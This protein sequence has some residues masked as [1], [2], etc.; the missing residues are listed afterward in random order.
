[1]LE[2]IGCVT[3]EHNLWLVALAAV[4]CFGGSALTLRLFGRMRCAPRDRRLLQLAMTCIIGGSTI[5]TTHF[6]AMLA[7]EPGIDHAY[8]PVLTALSLFAAIAGVTAAFA[9]ASAT[10]RSVLVEIGGALLGLSIAGMHYLGMEAFEVQGRLAWDDGYVVASI[11]LGTGF[12]AL[13][14]SRVVR[15]LTRYCW[16]GGVIALAIA[17]CTMH[18]TAMTAVSIELDPTVVAP[19]KLLS[20][21]T[22]SVL[23]VAVMSLFLLTGLASLLIESQIERKA[24][25]S[26]EHAA[27]HDSLTGLPNR[28]HLHR[29]VEDRA[30]ALASGALDRLAVLTVDLDRFKEINDMHGH[31]AGDAI[32]VD[33]ARRLRAE[34]GPDD[35]VAR[36]GGDEFLILK[37]GYASLD[38]VETFA[39][40]LRRELA[41]PVSVGS[42]EVATGV[43][44]GVAASPE[45]GSDVD[46]LKHKS[47]LAMY[48]AKENHLSAVCVFDAQLDEETRTKLALAHDL[49]QAL[50]QDQFELCYQAQNDVRTR[51]VVGFEALLRWNHPTRGRV[52]PGEFIP[53]AEKSG[54]IRPIGLWVLRTACREAARW[55]SGL[56][57]AVNVAPQQ[58][59]DPGFV[60]R[61]ADALTETGLDPRRL[62]LEITEASIIGDQQNTLEVMHR[63]KSMGIRIA[64]D[65][66][67]T[68][69]SSLASLRAFPFDKIKIDRSFVDKVHRNEQSAAIVRSTLLLGG[70]L[71][72]PVLAEG[73]ETEEE[74]AFLGAEQCS[75]VQG[76]LFGKPMTVDD[77][78]RIADADPDEQGAA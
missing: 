53:L 20:D 54:L 25:E 49:R 41:K 43:S 24:E 22:L 10:R 50:V 37:S 2:V 70:A 40:R 23:V 75:E 69:Y 45:H 1:M 12:G 17:I 30:A 36:T 27:L 61:V 59:V 42:A 14:L 72:I 63:L 47:D 19:T 62:E 64:M 67:G 33:T 78:R 39:D 29:V 28:A 76:F 66:F 44:I 71:A 35:F 68:G 13:A 58:L 57:I 26:F 38:D 34:I 21:A 11:V 73:V 32:L 6:I 5:W 4:V 18:F 52:S 60:E 77:T 56:R 7:Y 48:R 31:V 9:V 8:D 3:Q 55:R 74:L 16:F 46:E 65:D 51:D 15:P